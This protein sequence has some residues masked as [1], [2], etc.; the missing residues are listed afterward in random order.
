[1][2]THSI[3]RKV[4]IASASIMMCFATT[5]SIQSANAEP[6]VAAD[7]NL[8]VVDVPGMSTTDSILAFAAADPTYKEKAL[9]L[10]TAWES[11]SSETESRRSG[12]EVISQEDATKLVD[13]L[14]APV[15]HT[16]ESAKQAGLE[17]KPKGGVT[18]RSGGSQSDPEDLPIIG[19]DLLSSFTDMR[20]DSRG[21]WCYSN[22]TCDVDWTDWLQANV[23][24]NTGNQNV[25]F[26]W[27]ARWVEW[28]GNLSDDHFETFTLYDGVEVSLSNDG[29]IEPADTSGVGQVRTV[30]Y[31]NPTNLSLQ[32]NVFWAVKLW[33]RSPYGTD[34]SR[35]ART[36]TA[37]CGD[38]NADPPN[39]ACYFFDE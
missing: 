30:G 11:G 32:S 6:I 9:K 18:S 16:P 37:V 1:M 20:L 25:Q 38:L 10:A 15:V 26:S 23:T 2:N 19:T 31:I 13:L 39:P 34:F 3:S 21:R 24:I 33:N 35:G 5:V 14:E 36:P 17:V 28:E 12:Q 8:Y 7:E 27:N 4:G 29:N 22:G